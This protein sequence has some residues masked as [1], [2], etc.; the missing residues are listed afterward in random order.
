[1]PLSPSLCPPPTPTLLY[2]GFSGVLIYK[3]I[4]STFETFPTSFHISSTYS[5]A[6]VKIFIK[7]LSKWSQ[8][9]VLMP[10]IPATQEAEIRRIVV[11]SQHEQVVL[12]DPILKKTFT[13][14]GWWSGSRCR[15]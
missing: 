11:P 4:D 9:L 6:L 5:T 15:P 14:K 2:S 13:I 12:Q 3:P 8:A 1:M 7:H 10:I